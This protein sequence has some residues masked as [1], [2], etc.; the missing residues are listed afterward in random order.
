M[1]KRSRAVKPILTIARLAVMKVQRRSRVYWGDRL[2]P[3]TVAVDIM[4]RI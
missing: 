2:N 3:L 4:R 1:R